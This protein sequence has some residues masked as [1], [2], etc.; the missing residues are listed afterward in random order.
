LG[1]TNIDNEQEK[2][3]FTPPGSPWRSELEL[4]RVDHNLEIPVDKIKPSR[5]AHL[6]VNS[7]FH[8][9]VVE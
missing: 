7:Y 9:T 2:K 4:E 1:G 6:E 5:Y 8:A 3:K